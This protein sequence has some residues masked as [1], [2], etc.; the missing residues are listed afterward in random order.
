MNEELKKI[1]N[2]RRLDKVEIDGITIS[3]A[4]KGERV[5]LSQRAFITSYEDGF[6]TIANQFCSLLSLSSA[7]LNKCLVIIHEDNSADLYFNPPMTQ[8]VNLKTAT[9]KGDVITKKDIFDISEVF[10][11]DS[12][13][14][15]TPQEVDKIIFIFRE[16]FRFG[17]FYDFTKK[18]NIASLNKEIGNCYKKLHFYE[19]IS[20][21]REEECFDNIT[22]DG[23]FPFIAL[24]SSEFSEIIH[25]YQSEKE[26]SKRNYF[27]E[28]LFAKKFDSNKILSLTNNWWQKEQFSAKKKFIEAGINCFLEGNY[29]SCLST[30]YPIIEGIVGIDYFNQNGRKPKFKELVEYIQEKADIKYSCPNSLAYPR[31]FY[32]YLNKVVFKNFNLETGDVDL[33]RHSVLHG[34]ASEEDFNMTRSLQLILTLDQINFYL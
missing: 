16:G 11:K 29:I 25:L 1:Y 26:A 21:L 5:K 2:Y 4:I 3:S 14:D 31:E 27:L 18:N 10:F 9:K 6:D 22:A 33:S 7:S 17:I 28:E 23:W 34:Y 8:I 20:F 15:L 13:T 19:Q 24:I 12:I 32:D 30:L